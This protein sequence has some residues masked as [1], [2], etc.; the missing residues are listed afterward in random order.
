MLGVVGLGRAGKA[1]VDG[2]NGMTSSTT[3]DPRR[4]HE[5]VQETRTA[6]APRAPVCLYLEVT[7]RC[8]LLCTTCPRTYEDLEPPADLSW[9]LFTRIVDQVRTLPAPFCMASASRCW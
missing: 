8:N 7:N 4:Y 2:T 9:N 1:I 3:V 5:S 6:S